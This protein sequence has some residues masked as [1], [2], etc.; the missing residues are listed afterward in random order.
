MSNLVKIAD[1]LYLSFLSLPF[2]QWSLIHRLTSREITSRFKGTLF[3]SI[4]LL[5]TPIIMLAIYTFVFTYVFQARWNVTGTGADTNFVLILFIG[6]ILHSF[7]TDCLNAA[8]SMILQNT[9]YVKKVVFPLEILPLVKLFSNLIILAISFIVWMALFVYLDLSFSW[10]ML[11]FPIIV[12]P[13]GFVALSFMWLFSSLG[14]YLRD[15]TQITGLISTI[16]LFLSPIF[17]PLERLPE[18]I[19]PLI[20][21]NPLTLI[22][23]ESRKVLLFGSEPSWIFLGVYTMISFTFAWLSFIW[24]QKTKRGFADVL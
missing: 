14:V 11:L 24:F 22:V 6:L 4:W 18:S 1:D 5:L 2:R 3:G 10:N 23:E 20:Y 15:L 7:L 12:L 16:L 17:F 9:S 19:R 21:L 8:P 13:L